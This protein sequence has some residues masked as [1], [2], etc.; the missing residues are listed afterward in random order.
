M[1]SQQYIKSLDCGIRGATIFEVLENYPGLSDVFGDF[2]DN[3]MDFYFDVK[4][5]MLMPNQFPCIPNWHRDFVPRINN[6]PQLDL[7][8]IE[9]PLY[10]WLSGSPL[11]EFKDGRKIEPNK[12]IRFTQ[13]DIHRG[14]MST[15][16]Q[17]R[18]FIRAAH[19]NITPKN[20][21]ELGKVRHSQVYLDPDNFTW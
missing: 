18:L 11:T 6:I 8:Q 13:D 16:H 7:I 20:N 1:L 2:P 17:W 3:A 9:Y 14:T 4:V 5:H 12:W 15:E 19:K 21:I 10:L